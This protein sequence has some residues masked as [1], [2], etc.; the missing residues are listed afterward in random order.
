VLRT[1]IQGQPLQKKEANGDTGCGR[2][3]TAR[4]GG[5]MFTTWTGARGRRYSSRH[6]PSPRPPRGANTTQGRTQTGISTASA[7]RADTLIRTTGGSISSSGVD[8]E[9]ATAMSCISMWLARA[10]IVFRV[11]RSP[12]LVCS[13]Y[14]N[15]RRRIELARLVRGSANG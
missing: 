13:Y 8:L 15:R 6:P 5:M 7:S 3:G 14:I 10:G 1:L 11:S 9:A 2:T 12:T 4:G